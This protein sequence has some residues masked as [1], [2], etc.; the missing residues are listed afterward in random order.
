MGVYVGLMSADY[1]DILAHDNESAPQYLATG[2]ARSI[3]S[4]RI[5]YFFDWKGPS[6]TVDTACSSSLVAVHQAVQ[7]L[8]NGE[9]TA[10]VAAGTNLIFGPGMYIAESKLRMLSPTG[11]SRMWDA[12]ADGY[13]RGEGIGV[14][15]LKRLC[16]AIRDGDHIECVIRETGVNSDGHTTGITVPSASSQAELIRKTYR[17]AGLDPA[18]ESER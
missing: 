1:Y 15:V 3:L 14:V 18:K 12:N 7:A 9:C 4:N 11:G 17:R 8:R 13:T 16:D 2:T 5:S 6:I 10:A